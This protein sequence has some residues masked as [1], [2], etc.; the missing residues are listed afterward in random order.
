[1]N[2]ILYYFEAQEGAVRQLAA[3]GRIYRGDFRD[4]V[5]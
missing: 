3:V 5:L 2:R 1:M 4:L